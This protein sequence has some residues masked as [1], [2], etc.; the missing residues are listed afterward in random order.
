MGQAKQRGGRV[1]R[2]ADAIKRSTNSN[3]HTQGIP[4][5]VAPAYSSTALKAT[6][7]ILFNHLYQSATERGHWHVDQMYG[8]GTG[9]LS[10]LRAAEVACARQ[11]RV[12]SRSRFMRPLVGVYGPDQMRALFGAPPGDDCRQAYISGWR[13]GTPITPVCVICVCRDEGPF[14]SANRSLFREPRGYPAGLLS[15]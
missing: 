14:E 4:A 13:F 6:R 12:E 3:V 7:R 5:E 11:A 9:I 15:L 2:V 1:L 8:G 10:R